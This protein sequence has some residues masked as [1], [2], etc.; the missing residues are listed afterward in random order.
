MISV[1]YDHVSGRSFT[2][3][4]GYLSGN[5]RATAQRIHSVRLVVRVV[6][7]IHTIEHLR[8]DTEEAADLV[9]G[10]PE[11]RLPCSRRV[12][13]RVGHHIRPETSRVPDGPERLVDSSDRLT[14]PLD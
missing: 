8:S 12:S 14:V 6:M 3:G 1:K 2:F 7:A 5:C 9:N 10:D 11:L 4:C 13:Q